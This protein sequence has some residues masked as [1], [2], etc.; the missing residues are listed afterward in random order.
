MKKH[1]TQ[2]DLEN[3]QASDDLMKWWKDNGEIGDCKKL[4]IKLWDKGEYTYANELLFFLFE[5]KKEAVLFAIYIAELFIGKWERDEPDE[6]SPREAI[7]SAKAWVVEPNMEN[8]RKADNMQLK[9]WEL[10]FGLMFDKIHFGD[11][12]T[13]W[14][15]LYAG[16]A[17]TLSAKAASMNTT[18]DA[19]FHATYEIATIANPNFG[20]N[21]NNMFFEIINYAMSL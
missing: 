17:A 21:G 7:E 2:K 10:V 1:I 16:R 8:Q 6:H 11:V 5:S 12:S 14:P 15:A 19:A 3:W 18:E 13:S 4:L 20:N 9:S